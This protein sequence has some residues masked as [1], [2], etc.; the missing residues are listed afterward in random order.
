M[1]ERKIEMAKKYVRRGKRGLRVLLVM[2]EMFMVMFLAVVCYG[3]SIL[4]GLNRSDI[5]EGSVYVYDGSSNQGIVQLVNRGS[6]MMS[7]QE[8]GSEEGS[9]L[10]DEWTVETEVVETEEE[11]D[12]LAHQETVNGYWNILILGVDA[13]YDQ[14]L[15]KG[16]DYR[17]DV[18]MVCS[19]NAQTK[20]V[21][22]ASVY[23]DTI[24][25][26]Y[27][28]DKYVK[29]NDGVF[30]GFGGSVTEM[31]SMI[32]LNLDLN[33]KDVVV[34]NW[35]AVALAVNAMG[36]LEL[37][38]TQEEID[39]HIITGYLTDVV[40]ATGI[41]TNGQ[42]VTAGLQWC[43]GPKVVAY[44]RNRRTTGSDFGRAG[45][46]R[47]V[48]T[49][50]LDKAKA[51]DLGTLME[52]VNIVFNNMYTTL[53]IEELFALAAD[54]K[55]YTIGETMGFPQTNITPEYAGSLS[56]TYGIKDMVLATDL[57]SNVKALHTF[58]FGADGYQPSQDVQVISDNIKYLSEH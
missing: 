9:D 54:V 50:L 19:I 45:R 58:L 22:L 34:V 29:V 7:E 10:P 4:G 37:E 12:F 40:N 42:F 27:S 26:M 8:N 55:S 15:E 53:S 35:A 25:R 51:A 47:E 21:K 41:A 57:T 46:Q 2:A 44:C 18:I 33:I 36:G 11:F 14:P 3:V 56:T 43:D 6:E 48:I 39:R 52:V 31:I 24:M 17:A 1:T 5:D 49:K 16:G 23:R 28:K 38:I 30:S 20:N 13:T 32:N